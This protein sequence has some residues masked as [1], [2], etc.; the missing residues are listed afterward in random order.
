[1]VSPFVLPKRNCMRAT[2]SRY[3]LRLIRISRFV[4]LLAPAR[5]HCIIRTRAWKRA[6][7]NLSGLAS[8]KIPKCS[9]VRY[10]GAKAHS[11]MKIQTSAL[12]RGPNQPRPRVHIDREHASTYAHLASYSSHVRPVGYSI[13]KNKINKDPGINQ[14]LLQSDGVGTQ[15]AYSSEPLVMARHR[16]ARPSQPTCP[17]LKSAYSPYS[18]LGEATWTVCSGR[19]HILP[20]LASSRTGPWTGKLPGPTTE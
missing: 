17:L 18:I 3:P 5:R 16:V 10:Q 8:A 1:M 19:E 14:T 7:Q 4:R 12:G 20:D 2:T 9:P 6:V 11:Y 15:V 13:S